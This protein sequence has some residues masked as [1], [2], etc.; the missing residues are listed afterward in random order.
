MYDLA[1]L[2]GI[3]LK[4]EG[5]ARVILKAEGRARGVAGRARGVSGAIC[6]AI[7]PPNSAT[8]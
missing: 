8:G 5:R 7:R 4:A 1:G 2:G 3:C 6:R